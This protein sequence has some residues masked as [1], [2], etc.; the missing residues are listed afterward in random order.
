GS[1]RGLNVY[2]R[3]VCRRL[4][5]R[6]VATDVFTRGWLFTLSLPLIATT[7]WLVRRSAA[8]TADQENLQDD[9]AAAEDAEFDPRRVHPHLL[10]ATAITRMCNSEMHPAI[11]SEITGVSVAVIALHYHHPGPGGRLGGGNEGARLV[12]QFFEAQ[13]RIK[14]CRRTGGSQ[15]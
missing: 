1:N 3:E 2:V 10:R 13:G 15:P 9:Q 14:T 7:I 6:D 5:H 8:W 12:A 11:V 4:S